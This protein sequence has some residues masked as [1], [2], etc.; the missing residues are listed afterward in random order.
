[1]A[2]RVLSIMSLLLVATLVISLNGLQSVR[3]QTGG[4]TLWT[5]FN[6]KNTNEPNSQEK[7]MA[8]ALKD[9]TAKTKINITNV[10]QP[11]DQ[12]N[13][14]LNLAVQSKG[15]VPDVSYIDTVSLQFYLKNKALQDMT[16]YVKAQ[17]WFKDVTPG[18][19]ATCTGPDGKI[20][21]VPTSLAGASTY[22]WTSLYPN[23]FPKT[24]QELLAASKD[25]KAKDA[26][27]FGVTFKASENQSLTVA[28]FPLIA[29]AGGQIAD[30]KTGM[31]TWANPE[32]VE[33]VQWAREMFKGKHV[34]EVALSPGF[35]NETPF[36]QGAAGGF[37]AGSWSYVYLN[38][39]VSPD[40]TKFDHGADSVAKAAEAGKLGFAPPLAWKD[41]KPAL[42]VTGTAYAIPVGAKNVKGAQE[43]ITFQME[44]A[45]NVKFSASYGAIPVLNEALKDKA[46]QTPYWKVVSVNLT[47]YAQNAPALLDYD[48]GVAALTDT[49][50]KLIVDP[51]L[52]PMAELKASQDNYNAG[53]K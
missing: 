22:Y 25:I 38:P 47:T 33:V 13:A 40:G 11:Y 50:N 21:C 18:A 36:M 31:A 6:D 29:S 15:E 49:L 4:V 10:V 1:M 51:S 32:I 14:K 43:W 19:L 3:A 52:D 44:T 23:G 42:M 8:Q 20:Y 48:K 9:F 30:P 5:K 2:K 16:E 45:E 28:W 53:L 17:P 35:D 37:L 26:K 24:A 34:P 12:I 41:N 27:K 46:F 7:W 39:L